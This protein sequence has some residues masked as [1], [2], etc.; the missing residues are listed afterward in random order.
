M[1]KNIYIIVTIMIII[2]KEIWVLRSKSVIFIV[3]GSRF[4]DQDCVLDCFKIYI[5]E[6]RTGW[7]IMST[8]TFVYYLSRRHPHSSPDIREQLLKSYLDIFTEPSTKQPTQLHGALCGI[9]RLGVKVSVYL[10]CFVFSTLIPPNNFF[11][12]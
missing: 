6:F 8:F 1:W 4:I 12:K 9:K 7:L 5:H 2:E 3:S 11:L 10:F